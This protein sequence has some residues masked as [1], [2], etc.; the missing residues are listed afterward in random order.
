M[1][2]MRGASEETEGTLRRFALHLR[3]TFARFRAEASRFYL[4][5]FVLAL[6][7]GTLGLRVWFIEAFKIPS[8]GM[9][10]TL[11]IGDHIF[12]TKG[13][14]RPR[15][16]DPIVFTFP[17]DTRQDFIKRVVALPGDEVRFEAGQLIIN[18]WRVPRCA[19]GAL[20]F[21]D[22]EQPESKQPGQAYVEFLGER[23]YLVFDLDQEEVGSFDRY[24]V[25]PGELFVLGDN[26]RNSMDSRSWNQGRGGGVPLNL[27]RGRAWKVWMA[28]DAS[29]GI[30]T[31]RI[32]H[33]LLGSPLLPAD[34]PAAAREALSRCL[35]TPPA[36]TLPPPPGAG[37]DG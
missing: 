25:K 13:L 21:V 4:P 34:A 23:Q 16:G 33:D 22:R 3:N 20:T 11:L 36:T 32:G 2:T 35:A 26:R 12:A 30:V 14:Y 31:E 17:G 37:S 6:I 15:H 29:G 24:R 18:G 1:S 5:A 8:A 9:W 27:V 19:L 28:F 10:P 7:A